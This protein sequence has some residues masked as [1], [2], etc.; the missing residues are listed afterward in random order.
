VRVHLRRSRTALPAH[1]AR[2]IGPSPARAEPHDADAW[3]PVPDPHGLPS[4][5][6]LL[7]EARPFVIAEDPIDLTAL[8]AMVSESPARAEPHDAAAWL[9]LPGDVYD[10]PSLQALLDPHPEVQAA[11]VAEAEA[12]VADALAVAEASSAPSPARAE[13]HDP[14]SWLPLPNFEQLPP[15]TEL[16]DEGATPPT[17][18][19]RRATRL[20]PG[21]R[22]GFIGLLVV[23]TILAGAWGGSK[24][25]APGG[26]QVSLVVDGSRQEMRTDF[27]TVG[28][29]L[30]A[31]KVRLGPGDAVVPPASTALRDGLHIDVL[32]AFPINVDVDGRFRTVRTVETSADGLAKQMK[33]GKL[34]AVRNQPGRLSA[35]ATVV[36]R[37]RI[38]GSLKVDN[39]SVAFDSPS[40]T[41]DE[42]LDSYH[43]TLAGDDFVVPALGTVITNGAT[44]TVVRVGADVTQTHEVIPYDT[45]QQPDPT[46]AIGQT[47]VVQDGKDGTMV[48][49]YRQRIENG[50][51][52]DRTLLS[53][54][55]S[56]EPTPRIVGFGTYADPHWDQLAQCES[57]GR[58]STVDSAPASSAY[59]GGL[60]IF[61]GTWLAYGGGE[62]APN[63]GLAT[64]EQQITVG[65]RIYADLGWDP[66]GCANNVLHW[67]N[68]TS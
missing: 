62:F 48:M 8:E 23:A 35:G 34:T 28:S 27:A 51:K 58:W 30:A 10:L 26:S 57:G 1:I 47:R 37:T 17:G 3:L 2:V 43:V 5:E 65:M 53:K 60:G 13:P 56:V 39:Q 16:L 45:V 25:L 52:A 21:P 41:V 11:V 42:L 31:Q 14:T 38:S 22:V 18:I 40:R 9:P 55:P 66:W 6:M 29:L 33:L 44:V 4:I 59:D 15:V 54:V 63:A 36:F 61:R 24:L 20:L 68:Q 7:E 49:S 32:R 46:L 64:R 67:S 50:Q 12:L 19:R